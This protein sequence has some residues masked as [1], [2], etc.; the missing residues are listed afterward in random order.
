MNKI[1]N[2][3]RRHSYYYLTK[4]EYNTYFKILEVIQRVSTQKYIYIT[5]RL[6]LLN[7]L[8]IK[9]CQV[10]VKNPSFCPNQTPFRPN[11]IYNKG[12]G[13]TYIDI[14]EFEKRF[15]HNLDHEKNIQNSY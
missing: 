6:I 13:L 14:E 12:S 2:F 7:N 15:S 10:E 8:K 9:L 11:N 4:L 1:I 3:I 5:D